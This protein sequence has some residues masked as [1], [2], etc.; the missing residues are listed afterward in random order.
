[1]NS[2]IPYRR[3]VAAAA[4]LL[5][6]VLGTTA[7]ADAQ[8]FGR[9][10]G[11]RQTYPGAIAVG[12]QVGGNGNYALNGPTADCNC[13]FDNGSDFGYHAGLHLDI[14]VNR[15]FGVRLQGLYEDLSTTYATDRPAEI[16]VDDGSLVSITAQHRAEV[17]LQYATVSFSALWMTG[18]GGLYLLSGAGAG[19]Y[20]DGHILEE[21]YISDPPGLLYPETRSSRIVYRDEK[22]D[23]NEE[24]EIRALLMLGA[25]YDLPLGRGAALAPELQ[26]DI[27]IT[28]VVS[29]SPDW[30]IATLRA[31]FV[32][33]FGL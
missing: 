12:L 15:W 11:Y 29:G 2:A 16:Y 17:D 32:L 7:S 22:L 3:G 18:A 1:M 26:L 25:G 24:T 8:R 23:A 28:S 20:L 13:T 9:Y 19:F 30:R 10:H 14:L 31:S 5:S 27:P 4:L 33:R 6:L 21:E